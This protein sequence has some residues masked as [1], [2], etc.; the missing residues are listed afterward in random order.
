M[1]NFKQY[2][3]ICLLSFILYFIQSVEVLEPGCAK[4]KITPYLGDLE[5]VQG[6]F[7][8]PKGLIKL[9]HEK[10]ENGKIK[11]S[12]TAPEGIEIIESH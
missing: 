5:W 9:K 7:P 10:L 2:L 4:V 11:S 3:K 1:S 8:P 6:T 12:I